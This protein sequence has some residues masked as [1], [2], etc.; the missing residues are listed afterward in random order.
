M[1]KKQLFTAIFAACF[2][3]IAFAGTFAQASET[4]PETNEAGL[5]V[6]TEAPAQ[7]ETAA[8]KEEQD[9]PKETAAEEPAQ[10]TAAE[11]APAQ[12]EAETEPETE[13]PQSE[14]EFNHHRQQERQHVLY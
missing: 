4:T 10:E 7:P 12:T 6:E 14:T 13:E 5:P 2:M 3:T 9:L 8:Q 1:K 11:P